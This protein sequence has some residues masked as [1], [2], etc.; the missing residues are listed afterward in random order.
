MTEQSDTLVKLIHDAA[1]RVGPVDG[2]DGEAMARRAIRHERTR[3]GVLGGAVAVALVALGTVGTVWF[4]ERPALPAFLP[5]V[6]DSSDVTEV[7]SDGLVFEVP[8]DYEEFNPVGDPMWGPDPVIPGELDMESLPSAESWVAVEPGD[9]V[10]LVGEQVGNPVVETEVP[11]AVAARYSWYTADSAARPLAGEGSGDA[12]DFVGELD[13]ELGDGTVV[14]VTMNLHDDATPRATFE[15]FVDTVRADEEYDGPETLPMIPQEDLPLLE[16][17]EVPASWRQA[18][19]HGLEYAAPGDWTTVGSQGAN[20]GDAVHI[21]RPD[22]KVD[23]RIELT[24]H[25]MYLDNAQMAAEYAEMGEDLPY[26]RFDLADADVSQVRIERFDGEYQA[27][28]EV[29]RAG[30]RGYMVNLF[31]RPGAGNLDDD[32]A[33]VLGSLGLT[34]A[35][36]EGPTPYDD[37]D[38]AD[39]MLQDPPSG[40]EPVTFEGLDLR[41]PQ[42]LKSEDGTWGVW[43]SRSADAWEELSIGLWEMEAHE[44]PIDLDANGYRYEPPGTSRGVVTVG[45]DTETGEPLFQG[46]ATFYLTVDGRQA[47]EVG[48]GGAGATEERWW[49]ILASLD[50]AGLTVS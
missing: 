19:F 49:Q 18:E 24:D 45:T 5:W 30:G 21:K 42:E 37:L 9:G 23:L 40:W 17:G 31:G 36:A 14:R 2:I 25:L 26:Y 43:S 11:G 10:P 33:A 38:L 13:V 35:S 47:F 1:G 12:G 3:R 15:R 4:V 16:T 46:H 28:I 6:H 44:Q 29:R 39:P 8:G 27:Y 50:A 20:P 22:G 34:A 7:R 41:L 32:L 48:Y